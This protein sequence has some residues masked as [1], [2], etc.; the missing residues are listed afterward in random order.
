MAL[1]SSRP[2]SVVLGASLVALG[3]VWTL[4]N[5]GYLDLLYVLRRWWPLTLVGWGSLELY[6]AYSARELGD[7]G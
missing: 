5:L 6:R 7:R 2:E 1:S 3:V 4:S